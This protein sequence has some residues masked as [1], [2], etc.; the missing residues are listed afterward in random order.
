MKTSIKS[1][2][3]YVCNVV[4]SNKKNGELNNYE[5]KSKKYNILMIIEKK[6][7]STEKNMM[8]IVM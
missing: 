6:T 2:E 8:G 7:E 1:I 3:V 5:K 4:V